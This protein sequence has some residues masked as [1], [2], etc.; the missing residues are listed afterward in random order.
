M[1]LATSAVAVMLPVEDVDRAK[2]F[3]VEKLGLDYTGT[4]GEGSAM[5]T[6][7]GG[8]PLLLLPRPGA[9]RSSATALSWE[10]TDVAAEV[11]DLESRGVAFEDYDLPGLK[12]VDH[13]CELDSE[14][15][16]WFADPDGNML[17][18]HERTG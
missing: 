11:R 9:P 14:R 5:F 7:A 2:E 10:V 15:A 12:T 1:T 16:A 13:V 3:Y 18:L 4:N 8:T 6:L 17:C